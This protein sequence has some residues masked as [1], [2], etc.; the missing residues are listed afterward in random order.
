MA[1]IR[2]AAGVEA[3]V[4]GDGLVAALQSRGKVTATEAEN[5][6][7]KTMVTSLQS[8]LTSVVTA[9][10]RDK[11]VMAIETAIKDGKIVPA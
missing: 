9:N 10:A 7:L 1:R 5:A 6:E 8:Q 4:T 11:A 3:V 2:E